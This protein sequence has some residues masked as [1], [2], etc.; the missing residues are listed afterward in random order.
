MQ[1]VHTRNHIHK[2][3]VKKNVTLFD[4]FCG[5]W[6]RYPFIK[7]YIYLFIGV[8]MAQWIRHIPVD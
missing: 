6:K 1:A 7:F 2:I 8:V 4:K 3:S 5:F